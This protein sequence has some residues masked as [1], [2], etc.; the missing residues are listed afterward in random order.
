M[1]TSAR[2]SVAIHIL[3]ALGYLERKGVEWVTSKQIAK[4]VNTN[5]VVIRELLRALKHAGLVESKEGKGGGVRLARAASRISL[6][7][8]YAAVE[9]EALLA[10]NSKPK[11]APCPVSCGMKAVFK[12]VSDEVDQAVAN[13]LQ[14]KSLK[15]VIDRL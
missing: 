14:G 6:H 10:A 8:I 7:E 15:A 4:S 5:A 9:G 12:S 13:V 11:Y 1:S 2:F 3:A